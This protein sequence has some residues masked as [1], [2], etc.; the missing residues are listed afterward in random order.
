MTSYEEKLKALGL[1]ETLA[2][3][4]L[5]DPEAPGRSID[6]RL[7][8]Q[9]TYINERASMKVHVELEDLTHL[10]PTARVTPKSVQRDWWNGLPEA[11][12]RRRLKIMGAAGREG[13]KSTRRVKHRRAA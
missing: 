6:N 4:A 3:R 9:P 1:D 10:N 8:K 12:K 7:G 11:E 2:R 5:P 13:G